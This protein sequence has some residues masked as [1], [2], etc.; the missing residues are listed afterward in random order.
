MGPL[1]D[2]AVRGFRA[3]RAV[4]AG[5]GAVAVVLLLMAVVL[6]QTGAWPFARDDSTA[7]RSVPDARL[8]LPPSAL[9]SGGSPSGGED[10][11]DGDQGRSDEDGGSGGGDEGR[12]GQSA[13]TPGAG[14]RA[15]GGGGGP[16]EN[17]GCRA[18]WHVESQWE[19]FNATVRVLNTGR[20]PVRAWRITWTWPSGQRLVRGWNAGFRES[21]GAVTV[22]SGD[23]NARIPAGGETTFRLQATGG[24]SPAPLLVCHVL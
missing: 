23:G 19:D 13:S 16:A 7:E 18:T 21:G 2:G 3:V 24:G 14:M 10:D 5:G 4:T 6:H 1:A 20:R 11:E 15:P 22:R 17:C 8:P 12:P 9:G